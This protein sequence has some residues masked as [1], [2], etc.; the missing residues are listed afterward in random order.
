MKNDDFLQKMYPIHPY[1]KFALPF[2][3]H[4][5]TFAIEYIDI[6]GMNQDDKSLR[7]NV[8]HNLTFSHKLGCNFALDLFRHI[9]IDNW[10][11]CSNNIS[12]VHWLYMEDNDQDDKPYI[13]QI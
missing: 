7:T 6:A 4:N 5:N 8:D 1:H 3:Y 9:S 11:C 13:F 10:F 12:M 2:C